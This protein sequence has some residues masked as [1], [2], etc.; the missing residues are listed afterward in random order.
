[1]RR[2]YD[3]CSSCP[4]SFYMYEDVLGGCELLGAHLDDWPGNHPAWSPSKEECR[5]WRHIS[6]PLE[7]E[8]AVVSIK[9]RKNVPKYDIIGDIHGCWHELLILMRALGHKVEDGDDGILHDVGDRKL[10]FLG[11]LADRGPQSDE[12]ILYAM[13]MCRAQ[14]ARWIMGNHCDKLMRWAKGNKV[15]ENNGLDKTLDQLCE[16]KVDKGELFDFMSNLN[17]FLELDDGRLVVV[18]AAW[19]DEFRGI[20]DPS[21]RV[22]AYCIYGPTTGKVLENG[23]PDRIDWAMER[24][25]DRD[26]PLIIYGHQPVYAP[27]A[28]HKTI[29]ID[30][31]CVFGGHLTALRYPEMERVSVPSIEVYDDSKED[32]LTARRFVGT[33]PLESEI[34]DGI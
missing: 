19:K 30:T 1:M 17:Y 13:R 14:R 28:L 29:N 9:P 3:G 10:I 7:K 27:R 26:S 2:K 12:V 5:T 22:K 11:D 16:A 23:F 4:F 31:A 15:K 21:R 6:C 24:R 33:L 20:G 18:H 25:V 34:E 32:I 8:D